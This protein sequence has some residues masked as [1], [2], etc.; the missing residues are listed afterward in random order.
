MLF[1]RIDGEIWSQCRD[2]ATSKDKGEIQE[3]FA[4]AQDDGFFTHDA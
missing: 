2:N 3:S 4:F 1:R